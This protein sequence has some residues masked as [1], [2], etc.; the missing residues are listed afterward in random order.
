MLNQAILEE[1]RRVSA[2]LRH[3]NKN[4]EMVWMHSTATGEPD[5]NH[6]VYNVDRKHPGR[7]MEVGLNLVDAMLPLFG[8]E[9]IGMID[10]RI[11]PYSK[12]KIGESPIISETV[13]PVIGVDL[14]WE[15]A[16]Y[17]A[18]L[19]FETT[20]LHI[21]YCKE[22]WRED[23]NQVIEHPEIMSARHDVR[24]VVSMINTLVSHLGGAAPLDSWDELPP[25]RRYSDYER[26]AQL[27]RAQSQPALSAVK[28]DSSVPT[29]A[30]Q[31]TG[32]TGGKDL[33]SLIAELL[34]VILPLLVAAL[35]EYFQQQRG[36]G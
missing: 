11:T 3:R 4:F 25:D 21:R 8:V 29:T 36:V 6:Q 27:I 22:G 26:L 17:A 2:V 33:S 13:R 24:M 35:A 7:A 20:K 18:A 31:A 34:P 14:L 28:A 12:Y 16:Q 5:W 19:Y 23:K 15:A 1:I 10:D 9:P 30:A 32:T